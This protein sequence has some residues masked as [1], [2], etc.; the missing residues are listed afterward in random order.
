MVYFIC[1][2][3]I[4]LFICWILTKDQQSFNPQDEYEGKREEI[5]KRLGVTRVNW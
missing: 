3:A 4:I 2:V 1:V 5:R